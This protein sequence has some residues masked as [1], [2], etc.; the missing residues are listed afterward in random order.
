MYVGINL[1]CVD[2]ESTTP[3]FLRL[4]PPAPNLRRQPSCTFLYVGVLGI[5]DASLFSAMYVNVLRE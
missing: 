1:Q 2:I 3:A 4:R 5:G